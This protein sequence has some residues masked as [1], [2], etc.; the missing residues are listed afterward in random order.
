[1]TYRSGGPVP[2]NEA[3]AVLAAILGHDDSRYVFGC[4]H[5]D[6]PVEPEEG[7]PGVRLVLARTPDDLLKGKLTDR[8]FAEFAY[9][10]DE[11]AHE[12][13][14]S[15]H[16]TLGLV[17]PGSTL[18]PA[19]RP[20]E[21]R[22]RLSLGIRPVALLQYE[23][24]GGSGAD[25][26][27]NLN[28]G[29]QAGGVLQTGT[30]R[31]LR[32]RYAITGR[33]LTDDRFDSAAWSL[34]AT[35]TPQFH[36]FGNRVAADVAPNLTFRWLA[37]LTADHFSVSDPGR[38]TALLTANEFTRVGFDLEA[39]LRLALNDGNNSISLRGEYQLREAV[40][41]R[42]GDAQLL[43]VSLAFQPIDQVA[44]GLTYTRGENIDSLEFGEQW[45][46]T[47]G[48]RF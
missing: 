38:K 10:R 6:Q 47:F 34:A 41:G 33:Y 2:A 16:A 5:R 27:N 36:I 32:H 7:A 28:F 44:V 25:E 48:L 30:S 35:F 42:V 37:T 26:V 40:S 18:Q 21:G 22:S 23:R 39:G 20:G 13:T 15:I 19:S 11:V 12:S 45:K 9:T 46:F 8:A 17:F 24:E 3:E 43:N 31:T 4:T 1:M 29:F 14:Y